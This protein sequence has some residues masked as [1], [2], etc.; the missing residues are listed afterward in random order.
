MGIAKI[1]RP[2][3]AAS[4]VRYLLRPLDHAGR[5]R[6]QV[7][8]IGSTIGKT[9]EVAVSFLSALAQLRPRL[10]RHLYHVSISVPPNDR[11]L[12]RSGWAAIGRAWCA[13]MG[14]ENYMIGSVALTARPP[15]VP[16]VG[17]DG[18]SDGTAQESVQAASFPSGDHPSS[19][20]LVLSLP[21]VVPRRP[22]FAGRARGDGRC[23][24]DPPLGQEVR[25]RD[26][27]TGLWWPSFLAR[28]AMACR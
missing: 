16:W 15:Q 13:G 27:Q 20:A 5:E 26:P 10:R 4:T 17:N 14:I 11:E 18:G 6:G 25:P 9:P 3:R 28:A 21:A 1:S 24:H 12:S 8:V 22:R 19:G 7:A 23:L 2:R